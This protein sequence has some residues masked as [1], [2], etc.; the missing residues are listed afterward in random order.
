[1]TFE[2]NFP[3]LRGRQCDVTISFVS[4]YDDLQQTCVDKIKLRNVLTR[5]YGFD[6]DVWEELGL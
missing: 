1:M 3:S 6:K 4:F 5:Y 2:E